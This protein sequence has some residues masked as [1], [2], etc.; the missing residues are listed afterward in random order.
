MDL[1]GKTII[2]TGA[3][4]GLGR[5]M[6]EEIARHGANL[7]LVDLDKDETKVLEA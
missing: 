7:A 5:E 1:N 2:I 6:T 3:A 4:R